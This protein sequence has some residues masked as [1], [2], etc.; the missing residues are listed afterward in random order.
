V[1][2]SPR[3]NNLIDAIGDDDAVVAV[4]AAHEMQ[5]S[6][7]V[8]YPFRQ[9][10]NLRYLCGYE[11]PQAVLVVTKEVSVLFVEFADEEQR[12]WEGDSDSPERIQQQTQ[13]D[14][15]E[16][17]AALD[18]WL[19]EHANKQF[20]VPQTVR[21][22]LSSAQLNAAQSD[23]ADRLSRAG[24]KQIK[25]AS[26]ALAQ[27]RRVKDADEIKLIDLAA[28]VTI[29]A[30]D[31]LDMTSANYE[32]QLA[33]QLSAR[34]G[35][36]NYQHGYPVIVAGG[37]NATVLHYQRNAAQLPSE[38][39]VLI[40]VGAEGDGYTA[41]ISRTLTIGTP[42][43]R[44]QQLVSVITELQARA[45]ARIEPGIT[46][47]EIA[48]AFRQDLLETAQSLKLLDKSAELKDTIELMPH[49][50]SHYLG[51]DVHDVGAY[52]L[53]LEPGVVLTVEPGIYL[54]EEC[55][56]VRVEDYVVVTTDGCRVL[57]QKLQ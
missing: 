38:G 37:A 11:R 9:D 12:L 56:G 34:F 49:G 20:Y 23:L 33:A 8:N 2:Y 10:S 45:I 48:R 50:L 57:G 7:D 44:Q 26:P 25:D 53:P 21:P 39:L 6:S 3:R 4:S 46:V 32:Y 22:Q 36:Q 52:E 55:I 40:D 29:D 5:R 41:D 51:L 27:L 30:L 42:T 1:K 43:R 19:G 28:A 54:P 18:D 14:R 31:V 24:I 13:V 35:D 17:L 16:P 47:K 15:V